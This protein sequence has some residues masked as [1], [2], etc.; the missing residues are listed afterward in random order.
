[1][2]Q[3]IF[4]IEFVECNNFYLLFTAELVLVESVLALVLDDLIVNTIEKCCETVI[5][6]LTDVL[7][8]MIVAAIKSDR[9]G[10]EKEK[11]K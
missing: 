3:D 9:A 10:T 1:M 6:V 8:W 4:R 2:L 11:R 7:E 5:V